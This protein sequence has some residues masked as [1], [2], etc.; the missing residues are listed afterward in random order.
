M[1]RRYWKYYW[2]IELSVSDHQNDDHESIVYLLTSDPIIGKLA[3]EQSSSLVD[4]MNCHL[5]HE[6]FLSGFDIDINKFDLE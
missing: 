4:N 3:Y 5:N 2:K 1:D 6:K